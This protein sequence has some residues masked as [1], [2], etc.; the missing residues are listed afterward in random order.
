M[1]LLRGKTFV[2]T[3]GQTL[4]VPLSLDTHIFMNIDRSSVLEDL[5]YT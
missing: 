4:L 3:L 2:L 5:G 1:R